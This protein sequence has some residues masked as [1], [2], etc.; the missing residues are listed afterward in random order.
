MMAFE[1]MEPFGGLPDQFMAGQICAATR[2]AQR[3]S[4]DD[5][6]F[7]PADFMPALRRASEALDPPLRGEDLD[8]EALSNLLDATLFGRN[9]TV[10]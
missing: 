7:T 5:Y 9:P 4:K 3:M 6:L 10:H 2:N 8:D 1:S